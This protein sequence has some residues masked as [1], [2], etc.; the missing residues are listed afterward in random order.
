MILYNFADKIVFNILKKIN[1]GF[2]EIS[3]LSG[4]VLQFG[5]QMT[6]SK[7]I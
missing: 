7:Q 1:N 5:I 6:D 3:T 4:E 2:L